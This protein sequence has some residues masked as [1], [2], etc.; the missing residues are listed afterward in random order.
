MTRASRFTRECVSRAHRAFAR[1]RARPYTVSVVSQHAYARARRFL[2]FAAKAHVSQRLSEFLDVPD[3]MQL[4]HDGRLLRSRQRSD[5]ML[6]GMSRAS[7][8]R[9]I[10]CVLGG[11]C[12]FGALAWLSTQE[13]PGAN[14]TCM[15][16]WPLFLSLAHMSAPWKAY[17]MSV[18]GSLPT[19]SYPLCTGDLWMLYT[20]GLTTALVHDLP[21]QISR[22]PRD[23][24][25]IEGQLYENNSKLSP[26][27]TMWTWH[28][29]PDG[30]AAVVADTWVEVLHKGGIDDEHVGAWFLSARGS[31]IWF[32]VGRTVAFDDHADAWAYFGVEGLERD[33]RN[34]AMCANA[35]A[36]GYDSIQFIRH[37]CMMMYKPCLNT[38]KANLTYFNLEV[39]STRLTG[40][41]PCA[42]ADGASPLL[43]TGWPQAGRGAPCTCDNNASEHLHCAEVW[44]S[45][46][47]DL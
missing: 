19:Q 45:A 39:V 46:L 43:Q 6:T 31:G 13:L 25:V 23:E 8:K 11:L 32:N 4:D 47:R 26:P 3:A 21:D 20:S 30:F 37:T 18:Y 17:F 33:A 16:G 14:S 9:V 10:I 38:S 35:S 29:R 7:S 24:G 41:Y 42:S 15:G 34:E 27:N 5:G 40:I 22:C 36:V 2:N 28:P 12:A 1:A 44:P